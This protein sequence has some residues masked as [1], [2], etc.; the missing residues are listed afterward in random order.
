MAQAECG[1]SARDDTARRPAR[2]GFFKAMIVL[3]VFH[4]AGACVADADEALQ[5]LAGELADGKPW[6]MESREGKVSRLT[7]YPDGSGNLKGGPFE[8]SPRWR[9]TAEGFCLK[10]NAIMGE[11]CVVLVKRG[12]VFVA[13]QSGARAF[14]L[15][16]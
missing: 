14:T 5:G 9:A 10:P 11:R 4:A 15:R 16:R 6:I 3:A 12:D 7:L 13:E 2:S 1:H 8:M